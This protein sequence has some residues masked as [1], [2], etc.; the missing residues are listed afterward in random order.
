[1]QPT[2][3]ALET[4]ACRASPLHVPCHA[5]CFCSACSAWRNDAAAQQPPQH[6][7][8]TATAMP[9]RRHA[10]HR[11][12]LLSMH[13]AKARH[14]TSARMCPTHTHTHRQPP[15][16]RPTSAAPGVSG[17]ISPL[18]SSRHSAASATPVIGPETSGSLTS[19]KNG[20]KYSRGC[21]RAQESIARGQRQGGEGWAMAWVPEQ[22]LGC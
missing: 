4:R 14:R 3:T 9:L 2:C 18:L 11:R 16:D 8:S 22:W 6:R 7:H 10:P 17:V 5:A 13:A 12:A 21:T 1:M 15:P 20:A 19:F